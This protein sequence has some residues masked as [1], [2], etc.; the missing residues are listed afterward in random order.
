MVKSREE[1][2]REVLEGALRIG[3]DEK[4]AHVLA[5]ISVRRRLDGRVSRL[6]N[7]F[8][9]EYGDF[10]KRSKEMLADP[11]AFYRKSLGSGFRKYATLSYVC[12]ADASPVRTVFRIL[13]DAKTSRELD[14]GL[15]EGGLLERD[16]SVLDDHRFFREQR[17]DE[18][19]D[20]LLADM[21]ANGVT[22]DFVDAI[23][24][25]IGFDKLLDRDEYSGDLCFTHETAIRSLYRFF[26][27]PKYAGFRRRIRTARGEQRDALRTELA[28]A[29]S[30]AYRNDPEI[31]K[32]LNI[33][34]IRYTSECK[35]LYIIGYDENFR[36][37]TG[38]MPDDK[39]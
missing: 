15:Q 24:G 23:F 33:P 6:L 26:E 16:E 19:K 31:N 38:P 17:E 7:R 12:Y 5:T 10:I 18:R 28:S 1:R 9:V 25:H 29:F 13:K 37:V 34:G 27:S 11:E 32:D 3:L 36:A 21:R 4:Y 30:E 39:C 35:P 2:F 22:K 20:V 8:D 14:S